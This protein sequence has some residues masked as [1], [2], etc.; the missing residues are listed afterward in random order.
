M[1]ERDYFVILIIDGRI[2]L[3]RA[4]IWIRFSRLRE[5]SVTKSSNSVNKHTARTQE[6]VSLSQP[7]DCRN[8][9]EVFV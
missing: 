1:K 6:K 2:I 5:A 9:N 7:S 4:K 3:K 8:A